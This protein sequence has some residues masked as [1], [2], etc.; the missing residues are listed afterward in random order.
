[1]FPNK[2]LSFNYFFCIHEI[3]SSCLLPDTV[4]SSF[5]N[6]GASQK[7]K[8]SCVGVMGLLGFDYR[9][10]KNGA[11]QAGTENPNLI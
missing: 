9:M 1:M 4:A 7:Q 6:T 5:H 8:M 10:L 2:L 3:F 11:S